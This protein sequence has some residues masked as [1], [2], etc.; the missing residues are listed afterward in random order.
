[1]TTELK[2]AV[3]ADEVAST[4]NTAQRTPAERAQVAEEQRALIASTASQ[5]HGVVIKDTGDGALMA[6]SSCSDAVSCGCVL[7]ERAKERNEAHANPRLRF[8][9]HIGADLG[10]SLVL[11]DGDMRANATNLAARVCAECPAGEVFIT[12]KVM[13]ELHPKEVRAEKVGSL[14][15]KGVKKKITVY[16]VISWLGKLSPPPN[17]FIWRSG[18]TERSA[19]FGRE[20]E[21]TAV[22]E[23]VVKGQN[24][25]IIGPS[26]IGKTSLLL[27][28]DRIAREKDP[29][30]VVAYMDLQ[31]PRCF[32]LG[33]WLRHVARRFGWSS[34]ISQMTQFAEAIDEMRKQGKRPVLCLDG[35]EELTSRAR[36]FTGDFFLA[37]RSCSQQGM[38]IV[39]TSRKPLSDVTDKG[40]PTSPFYNSFAVLPMKAFSPQ[41]ASDFVATYR[42]G[43]PPFTKNERTEILRFADR[44]PLALQVACYHV[45][46]AKRSDNT[47]AAALEDA[48][49]ELSEY[50]RE[51]R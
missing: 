21:L 9:L 47:L 3:F 48:R 10:E 30:I 5:C 24:R 12:Q 16:R 49:L 7:Q 18:I 44:H 4:P 43:V 38:P 40:D 37:L 28:V 35:F 20:R 51:Q 45:L 46:A 25:Q 42:S 8:E 13:N 31:D 50:L 23:F 34:G 2:V 11:A 17:P 39:T 1:M 15:L 19:F 41:D 32:T 36:Q 33:D 14:R 22:L 6:F 27:Q 26:R 29:S